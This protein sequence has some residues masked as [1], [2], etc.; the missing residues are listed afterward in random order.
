MSVIKSAITV[1]VFTFLSRILGFIRECLFT[2]FLG[3]SAAL[4]CFLVAVRLANTCRKIFAEGAFNASFLPRFSSVLETKSIEEANT[5]LS[6]V[7]SL[8]LVFVSIFCILII[9]LYP[10]FL[11]II[12]SGF[13]SSKEQ[14]DMA[15]TLGRITFPF[16]LFVSLTA[17]FCGVANASKKFALPAII[18]SAVNVFSI[19][20]V[21]I[22]HFCGYSV[23]ENIFYISIGVLASGI[24]QVVVMYYYVVH[25]GYKIK[26]TTNFFS[27]DVNSILKNMIPGIIG[28]GVWQINMLI[29]MQV[30]SYLP[31]GTISCINF[32]DKL[33]QFPLATIGTAIGTALLPVLS[34]SISK[35]DMRSANSDLQTGILFAMLF[36]IPAFVVLFALAHP[37]VSCAY[38]R[39]KFSSEH[40]IIVGDTLRGFVIGL[41]A[42][43]LAKIFSSAFFANRDTVTP[44]KCATLSVFANILFLIAFVPL[45]RIFCVPLSTALSAWVNVISLGVILF[46]RYKFNLNLVFW[47]RFF[48]QVTS[49]VILF[50]EMTYICNTF[51]NPIFGESYHKWICTC[52]FGIISLISYFSFISFFMFASREQNIKF[53]EISSW[54]V[55]V[56]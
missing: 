30:C 48:I 49:G 39:I 53:W 44:I 12:A 17:L 24:F 55:S 14:F 21:V 45:G 5:L 40:V 38:E 37:I 20:T 10:N 27:K 43:I 42:Y 41:P 47:K 19:V 35:K 54:T 7:F 2:A 34:S 11:Y 23:E 8:M 29:D 26:F 31:A 32:A 36:A 16:L 33:N 51:W 18:F 56:K 6:K 28:A 13:K 46:K 22:C 25:L 1:S 15:V 3:V 4:D 52:V 50:F 9:I